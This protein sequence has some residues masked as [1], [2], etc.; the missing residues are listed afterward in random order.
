M[1][2]KNLYLLPILKSKTKEI[3]TKALAKS[4]FAKANYFYHLAFSRD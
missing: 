1:N 4:A 2:R 3:Y